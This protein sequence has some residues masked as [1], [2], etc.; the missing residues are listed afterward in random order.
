MQLQRSPTVSLVVEFSQVRN[1][2]DA[3]RYWAEALESGNFSKSIIFDPVTGFGGNGTGANLCL[4][5]GPFKNYKLSIGPGYNLT[6]HCLKR[7][8]DDLLSDNA[9]DYYVQICMGYQTYEEAWPCWEN[10]PHIG[11]HSG[12]G[13]E[14]RLIPPR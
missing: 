2:P 11:G 9:N 7:K 4:A 14:V 6:D 12:T 3:F 10:S 8:I 13:G 1:H 5:D